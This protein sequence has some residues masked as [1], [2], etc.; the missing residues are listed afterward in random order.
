MPSFAVRNF[1]CR[2][3]QAE[4]FAWADAFRERGLR[5]DEDWGRSDV[6]VV[7]SCAL[8]GRAERDVRKFIRAVHRGHPATRIVVTGCYAERAPS[9]LAGM[10]GVAA[11]LPQ[12]EKSGLAERL[13]AIGGMEGT[14]GAVSETPGHS[15][16]A[17]SIPAMTREPRESED[18]PLFRTRGW[19]KIQD[20]CDERCS[21]CIIP[22]VRGR[23]RS[24]P[25]SDLVR[26]VRDL[27][28]RDFREIVLAGI[29]LSSYGEDLEP[30]SSLRE[31]VEAL[32]EAGGP[33]R[34]RLSSLDPRKTDRRLMADLAARARICPHFH[35][36]L[37]HASSRIL[38]LMGRPGAAGSYGP[39]LE[40]M[41]RLSPDAA[42]GADLMVG[43]P[44]ETEADF[45]ALR[46]FVEGAPLTYVHVFSFSPRPG[47]PAAER[48]L[49]APGIVTER[50]KAL[51]RLAALKGFA[52]RRRFIGRELEAVVIG[53]HDGGAEVLTGNFIRV[54][55]PRGQTRVGGLVRVAIRRVLPR[56]T[57]GEVRP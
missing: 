3:N 20:G 46:S 6:V 52:F 32:D 54:R 12:S 57:E 40:E 43:F 23:S 28:R 24:L 5:L 19:L 38:G 48:P 11:V 42:L 9:E 37:Q 14:D 8:T 36:S 22:R 29:H 39:I 34:F 27:S 15:S 18:D 45:E 4:A 10:P 41:R 33:A 13:L 30:R 55:I 31:L 53:R 21:Y 50:A 26:T 51:R 2:V 56:R 49:I 47:T 25:A 7:N 17:P 44:G 35:F 1:G 16:A